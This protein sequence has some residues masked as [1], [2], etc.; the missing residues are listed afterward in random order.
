MGP[1]RKIEPRRV[2]RHGV[3]FHPEIGKMAGKLDG[4]AEL[5][6]ARPALLRF[7]RLRPGISECDNSVKYRAFRRA[8]GIHAKVALPFKLAAIPLFRLRQRRFQS[9]RN[10]PKGIGIQ[11]TS[12]VFRFVID[13][14]RIFGQKQVVVQ[15]HFCWDRMRCANPMQCGF[16]FPSIRRAAAFGFRIVCAPDFHDVAIIV[17]DNFVA[18]DEVRPSQPHF[19]TG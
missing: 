5:Y 7:L 12:P 8:V 11:I 16:D 18:R 6:A 3:D 15:S 17:F 13:I 4:I 10:N 19:A 9:G 1:Q 2:S 14:V